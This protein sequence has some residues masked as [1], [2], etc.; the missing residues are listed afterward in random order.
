MTDR[1]SGATGNR[2]MVR[3]TTWNLVGMCSPMVVALFAIPFLI[4]GLGKDRFGILTLVWML[5]GYLSVFDLGLGRALTQSVAQRIGEG[6]EGEIPG[7]FRSAMI[8][9]T[10]I[11]TLGGVVVWFIAPWLTS[12]ALNIEPALQPETLLA[13]RVVAFGLPMV[14]SNSGLVGTLEAF[15]RFGLVN[16]IRVPTGAY[17]FLGPLLVLPFSR[18]LYAVVLALIA[19]R[20]AQWAIYLIACLIQ[21]PRTTH[22]AKTERVHIHEMLRF[23]GWMTVSNL[24]APLLLHMD[25]FLIGALRAVGEVTYYATPAEMVLKMLILPRAWAGVLFPSFAGSYRLRLADTA[26]LFLRACR[27]LLS[28]VFPIIAIVIALAP[29]FLTLWIGPDFGINSAPVMRLLTAGI[30]MHSLAIVPIALLQATSR[31]DMA[32][33]LNLLEIPF[34]LGCASL[35]IT[36]FGIV[37]ASATWVARAVVD[38]AFN[39]LFALR[40]LKQPGS[41]VRRFAIVATVDMIALAVLALPVHWLIRAGCWALFSLLHG[42]VCWVW[43]LEAGDKSRLTNQL[44]NVIQTGKTWL[45]E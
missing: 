31:P 5:V 39:T 35:L 37:G 23:G 44:I 3:H 9:M 26:A 24:L 33:K 12:S 45:S 19:G 14:V 21:I 28:A 2:H 6:R 16:A 11:G 36:R 27:Y 7:V 10:S 13:F 34:Y 30:F 4:E 20:V 8:L 42:T 40:V 17:T 29:E 22:L 41:A 38:A 1:T 43:L 25:R 32:A 15:R 18:S